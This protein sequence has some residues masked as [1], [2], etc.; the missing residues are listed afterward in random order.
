MLNIKLLFIRMNLA[1][2]NGLTI[3]VKERGRERK[4]EGERE[5]GGREG[6]GGE[7]KGEREGCV[8]LAVGVGGRG[9]EQLV[10]ERFDSRSGYTLH[11]S[12]AIN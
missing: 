11:G 4:K 5:G 7:R 10:V 6:R 9:K 8:G 1:M 3:K 2:K 12:R